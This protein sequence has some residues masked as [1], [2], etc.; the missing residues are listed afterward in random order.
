MKEC[1][2][3]KYLA[4]ITKKK[5]GANVFKSSKDHIIQLG[6]TVIDMEEATNNV[7]CLTNTSEIQNLIDHMSQESC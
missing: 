2:K 3:H 7:N 6:T 1:L 5:E 4:S